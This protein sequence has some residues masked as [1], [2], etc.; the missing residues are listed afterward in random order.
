ML[1]ELCVISLCLHTGNKLR[2]KIKN[3]ADRTGDEDNPDLQ[4]LPEF[5]NDVDKACQKFFRNKIDPLFGGRRDDQL[6]LLSLDDDRSDQEKAVNLDLGIASVNM[7]LTLVSKSLYPPMIVFFSLPTLLWFSVGFYKEAWRQLFVERKIGVSVL[8]VVLVTYI[9]LT[10]RMFA[11]AVAAFLLQLS[12]KLIVRTKDNSE[13]KLIHVF[14]RHPRSVWILVGGVETEIA[15]EELQTGD[16]VVVNAGEIIPADGSITEGAALVAEQ[17]LTG[18]SVPSEKGAGDEVFA[19]TILLSGKIRMLTGK[20]G[21]ETTA[22]KIGEI[23][24][25]TTGH[26]T[27]LESKA[28]TIAD[29][30]ILPTLAV[31]ALAYPIAGTGGMLAVLFSCMGYGMRIIGPLSTLNFL[32]AASNSN[33][34]VK[35][36]GALEKL[37]NIDVVVFDKTGTLTLE[38]PYVERIHSFSESFSEDLLLSYAAAAEH[39]QTHPIA[40]AIVGAAESRGLN[41]PEN[42]A[43]SYNIGFGIAANVS[44]QIVRVGSRNFMET[45]G[46]PVSDTALNLGKECGNRGHSLVMVAVGEELAGAIELRPGIRPEAKQI[47]DALRQR[48]I[49]TC[50]ISGDQKQPTKALARTLGVDDYFAEVLPERK[51]EIV[52]KIQQEG[53]TVCFVG[54]GIND[55][56]ALKTADVSISLSGASTA[57]VD[58]AQI[59]LMD[60]DLKSFLWVMDMSRE[61]E[62]RQNSNLMISIVPSV[63]CTGGVFLFHFGL[64]MAMVF[65][66]SGVVVGIGNSLRIPSADSDKSEPEQTPETG[67]V[68][69]NDEEPEKRLMFCRNKQQ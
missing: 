60:E 33:V 13:K 28:E 63:I 65:Y 39:R 18:E 2:Q 14:S 4:G 46:I 53:K 21:V 52:E 23:L 25:L 29:R 43:G 22:G 57:A 9:V 5:G 11:G 24:T 34:L 38:Q 64:Y 58:S 10:G 61:F 69:R 42:E 67:N 26:K 49:R 40:K 3:G 50:I 68:F 7:A 16:I 55:L 17:S 27:S 66:Y 51:A 6:K 30:S 35:D 62:A 45:E 20:T 47:V 36:G 54:D 41:L 56:I 32:R 48:K 12:R 37:C 8:N 59:I 1:I 31:G 15:F 44:G 19:S